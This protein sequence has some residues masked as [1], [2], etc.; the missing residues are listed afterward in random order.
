MSNVV[1]ITY[2]PDLIT[3]VNG[4]VM[5]T[6]GLIVGELS[7][8]ARSG[9]Y[10][11]GCLPHGKYLLNNARKLPLDPKYKAYMNEDYPWG[12]NLSPLFKTTRTGLMI[13]ADGNIPGSLG[14]I[15]IYEKDIQCF[16]TLSELMKKN[17]VNLFCV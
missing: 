7:F 8:Q 4:I 5:T 9:G 17:V 13:H 16:E 11:N 6:G 3:L 1:N 10:G 12:I 14:C 2:R 15:A